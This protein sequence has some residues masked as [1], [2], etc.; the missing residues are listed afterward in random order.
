MK[1]IVLSALCA[2]L[3]G[4][5]SS[6]D[7]TKDPTKIDPP[8]NM[9]ETVHQHAFT[10]GLCECGDFDDAYCTSAYDDL[11]YEMS[12]L[13]TYV[14]V[15]DIKKSIDRLPASYRDVA[16]ISSEYNKIYN[17]FSQMQDQYLEYLSNMLRDEEEKVF[18]DFDLIKSCCNDLLSLENLLDHD[19][20]LKPPLFNYFSGSL[21]SWACAF[22]KGYYSNIDDY[23]VSFMVSDTNSLLFKTNIPRNLLSDTKYS[24]TIEDRDIYY[25]PE[26]SDSM[27]LAFQIKDF[28]ADTLQIYCYKNTTLYTLYYHPV[29][30]VCNHKFDGDTYCLYCSYKKPES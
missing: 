6:C 28:T 18:I 12:H 17:L 14:D 30:V 13:G 27:V 4:C 22:F 8:S 1:K 9:T 16:V 5:L 10:N 19:W 24:W 21:C 25:V 29:G 7:E 15:V 3:I 11:I 23:Y 2:I 26:N 20:S